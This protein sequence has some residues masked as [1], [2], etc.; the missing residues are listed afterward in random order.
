M[1]ISTV[2]LCVGIR[3][4]LELLEEAII[5]SEIYGLGRGTFRDRGIKRRIHKRGACRVGRTEKRTFV[6]KFERREKVYKR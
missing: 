3:I 4:K 1:F 6:V 2:R 5:N